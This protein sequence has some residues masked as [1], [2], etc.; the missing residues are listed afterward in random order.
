MAFTRFGNM[1]AGEETDK[2]PYLID[3]DPFQIMGNLYYVGNLWCASHLID[4]GEGLILLDVPCCSGYPGL[5]YNIQKLGFCVDDIKYIVISHAHTDHYGCV[6]ALVHRTHAKTFM[7]RVDTEDMLANPERT[8]RLDAGLGPYNEPFM[9]D[10]Q[11]EDGDVIELGNVK[12]RCV[13]TPGHTVGVMS[14][15]WDME[16]NG[17]T[18]HVGIYGGA[19]YGS[20]STEGLKKFG[21]PLTMQKVFTES[22]EKVWDEP[23]DLML[24]NHPFHSDEYQKNMRRAQGEENPFVDPTEWHRFLTELR[25]GFEDFLNYSHEEMEEFFQASHFDEYYADLF[26][27]EKSLQEN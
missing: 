12:M 14:H 6:Q 26:A 19:G 11:L 22:I 1:F 20:L 21:Q 27:Y 2:R 24:G 13:L 8:K 23:V 4:T 9:P 16:V 18:I 5:L 15:F 17:K 3:R 10:V 7:G 25:T